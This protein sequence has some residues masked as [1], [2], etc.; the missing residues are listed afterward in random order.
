MA[1]LTAQ[2]CSSCVPSL[3]SSYCRSLISGVGVSCRGVH[4]LSQMV[5]E[6]R[7]GGQVQPCVGLK[8]E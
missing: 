3:M 8:R 6:D 4:S 1:S 5:K 7:V 2:L